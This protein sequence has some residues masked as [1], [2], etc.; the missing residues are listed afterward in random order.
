MIGAIIGDVVGSIYEFDNLRSKTFPLF[1]R[2]STYT[3]DTIMSIAVAEFIISDNLPSQARLVGQLHDWFKK[4]PDESYGARFTTWM[5]S[6]ERIN[7]TDFKPYNSFGNGAAMR[8]SAIGDYSRTI[9][10]AMSKADFV[11]NVSHNHPEGV[12][13][14]QATASLIV[15]ART[16]KDKSKLREFVE[17]EFGYNLNNSVDFLRANYKYNETCQATVPEAIICFLESVDFEDA[18]RNAISIG[19]DSDTLACITGSIAEAY[20]QSIPKEI[21][22]QTIDRLPAD[23]LLVVK[24]F[25]RE[26]GHEY[27]EI[28]KS[29]NELIK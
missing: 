17:S 22:K 4:Y 21:L 5:Q 7:Y 15:M 25:Y 27:P 1:K 28:T 6:F 10:E 19:G 26:I 29:I 12:K 8:I 2:E 18:I 20:Y 9:S 23:V 13:G 16:E 14:A 3:D 24:K 11:T